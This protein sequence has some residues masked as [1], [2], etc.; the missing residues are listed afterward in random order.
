MLT[1]L[2]PGVR[3]GAYIVGISFAIEDGP[4][5]Y[6]PIRHQ[7]GDNLD[8]AA[9]WSYLRD[10]TAVFHGDLAFANGSYDLDFLEEAGIHFNPRFHRDVQIAEPLLDEQQFK[11]SLEDIAE[12]YG[13]PGKAEDLLTLAARRYGLHPKKDLWRLPARYIGAYAEQDAKLPL[14]LLR[15]QERELD[16]Q[17][18]FRIYDL[19]SRVLPILVKM[20]R[21]GVRIDLARLDEVERWLSNEET[22]ALNK[23]HDLSG[24]RLSFADVWAA[25]ALAPVLTPLGVTIP[26]TPKTKKPSVDKDFLAGLKGDLPRAVERARQLDKIRR[27]YVR[28]IRDHLVNGRI[29]ATFN[30]LKMTRDD[31]DDSG[32][33]TGR[34]SCADPNM[35]QMPARDPELGPMWRSIF[36]PDE[37]LHWV[38]LDYS[39]QEPRMTVHYAAVS[40]CTGAEALA[41][42]FRTD[43]HMF[44]PKLRVDLHQA[45]ADLCKIKRK[46]A[47]TIF[48]GLCYGMGGAKLCAKL[49]LPTEWVFSKRK[50][51]NIEV[52]GE[53]GQALIDKFHTMVPFVKELSEKVQAAGAKYGYI[54]TIGGRRCRFP[55][56]VDASTETWKVYDHLHKGLNKLIQ[57][58]SA[59]QT[60]TALVQIDAAGHAIQLQIHDEICLSVADQAQADAVAKIMMECVPLRVP[61][62]VDAK[63]APNWGAAK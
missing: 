43:P 34:L 8:E 9:V 11:Y 36:I 16:A 24:V 12:R 4:S 56:D 18:L 53:A 26:I 1:T 22:N 35:Q 25:E 38:S 45:T 3:R 48:L 44:D 40:G 41:E 14:Q 57:G 5:A 28:T 27:D 50:K 62:I 7:G 39:S 20:R 30:Q 2:G 51:R 58:S 46:D 60:K 13:F 17:G 32:T 61:S 23:V 10:Q 15:K 21:R 47:K 6:L 19:E 54:R 31:G 59:D 63:I 33:I 55:L 42:K 49:G 29:H 52:A 37:G